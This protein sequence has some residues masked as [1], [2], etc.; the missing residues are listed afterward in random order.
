MSSS[1]KTELKFTKQSSETR[2]L[3]A[4]G[5]RMIEESL[6]TVF[7]TLKQIL[8]LSTVMLGGIIALVDK[9]FIC[10][11]FKSAAACAF[12]LSAAFSFIGMLP[13]T[14]N[15]SLN[16][17]HTIKEAREKAMRYQTHWLWVSGICLFVGFL[18]ATIGVMFV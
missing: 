5:K 18:I 9:N 10:V 16:F 6:E 15:I 8:T 11:G 4:L 17:P 1:E 12:L 7:N 2:E 14:A 13:R 3:I